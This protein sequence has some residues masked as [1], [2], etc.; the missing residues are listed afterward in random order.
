MNDSESQA[1]NTFFSQGLWDHTIDANGYLAEVNDVHTDLTAWPSVPPATI[2]SVTTTI[3]D[4]NTLPNFGSDQAFYPPQ[5]S[6][7]Y[8]SIV[9]LTHPASALFPLHHL[10]PHPMHPNIRSHS[11]D[12]NSHNPSAPVTYSNSISGMP[13]HSQPLPEPIAA[14]FPQ[15]NVP[16][17]VDASVSEQIAEGA[18]RLVQAAEQG[19]RSRPTL[20]KSYTYGTDSSFRDSGFTPM[21]KRDSDAFVTQRLLNELQHAEPLARPLNRLPNTP[22]L[23]TPR[24]GQLV[25]EPM[26]DYEPSE[27]EFPDNEYGRRK[28][29]Q[30]SGESPNKSGS[31]R[32]R[33]SVSDAVP[34]KNRKSSTDDRVTKRKRSSATD[35]R[36]Q[37][38]NLTDAQ[39]RSN[40]IASEQKRRNLIKRGFDDLHELVPEIRSGGLSK[41]SVLTEAAN[42]LEKLMQENQEYEALLS[43]THPKD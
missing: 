33:K 3:Q 25:G 18:A 19:R 35:Q 2:H 10:P 15:H 38:Q 27:E 22:A 6:G 9:D 28:K 12:V 43:Q 24:P 5:Q 21:S 13:S 31:G 1:L 40:H 20:K 14:L 36:I 37:R 42:Y 17:S 11:F 16:G 32:A 41:S 26:S 29:R 23:A 30:R 39:K 4:P 7:P 34:V 8:P